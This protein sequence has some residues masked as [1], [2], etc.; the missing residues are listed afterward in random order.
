MLDAKG[1]ATAIVV[2]CSCGSGMGVYPSARE[3]M[4]VGLTP[5][6]PAIGLLVRGA[7]SPTLG[8][9]WRSNTSN[10]PVACSCCPAIEKVA[11]A[12]Q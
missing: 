10:A 7:G 3:S 12:Y 4:A 9:R 8:T 6:S 5:T 11:A 1:E 2:A